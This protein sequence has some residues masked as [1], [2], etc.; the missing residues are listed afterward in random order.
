MLDSLKRAD[1]AAKLLAHLGVFHTHVQ[2]L[3]RAPAHFGAQGDFALID[4]AG[5]IIPALAGRSQQSVG[6]DMHIVQGHCAQLARLIHG[7]EQTGSKAGLVAVEHKQRH[8]FGGARG[9][10]DM[11]DNMGVRHE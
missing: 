2:H 9:T 6:P 8:P 11:I 7:L 10:D 3:L 5:Q 4:D 1:R